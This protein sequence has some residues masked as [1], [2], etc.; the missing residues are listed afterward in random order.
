MGNRVLF[1]SLE[2][3]AA[4]LYERII[5]KLLGISTDELAEKVKTDEN[6]IL[7][8]KVQIEQTHKDKLFI[9]D[10]NDLSM[11][12]VLEKINTLN[13]YLDKPVDMVI[14]DYIQ[15]VKMGS[16][17]YKDFAIGVRKL[18]L[19]AKETNAVILA[20]SQMNRE[21]DV[22]SRPTFKMLRGGGD[23]EA[24]ADICALFW[25]PGENQKLSL[26]EQDSLRNV[27]MCAIDKARRGVRVREFELIMEPEKSRIR[28]R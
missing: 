4:S 9:I 6:E 28:E 14:I 22:F 12:D 25:R 1:F 3:S 18:K 15:Y 13:M 19:I 21:A 8:I 5:A 20:L 26:E 16:G 10:K 17:E 7:R 2:M 11:D 27:I 24:T 23:L